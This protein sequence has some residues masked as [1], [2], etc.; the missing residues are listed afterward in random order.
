MGSND[1]WGIFPNVKINY[2]SDKKI[3]PKFDFFIGIWY[4][5]IEVRVKYKISAFFES[6]FHS[7][8]SFVSESIFMA[9]HLGRFPITNCGK[10]WTNNK[11][12]NKACGYDMVWYDLNSLKI[13]AFRVN[14][15]ASFEEVESHCMRKRLRKLIV[16]NKIWK[17]KIKYWNSITLNWK[18]VTIRH[19]TK[20]NWNHCFWIMNPNE[21]FWNSF[22]EWIVR[23]KTHIKNED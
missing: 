4:S 6:S 12:I 9:L 17:L 15:K 13:Q 10:T 19:W 7:Q 18:L 21:K 22:P 14:V 16:L 8:I 11:Q 5:F 2:H 20:I 1:W 23:K 3:P